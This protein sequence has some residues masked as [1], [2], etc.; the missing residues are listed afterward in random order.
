MGQPKLIE[1]ID[2][3]RQPRKLDKQGTFETMDYLE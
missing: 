2:H 1:L 3:T